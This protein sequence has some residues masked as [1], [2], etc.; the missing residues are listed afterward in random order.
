MVILD[1]GVCPD[2]HLDISRRFW[3]KL[4]KVENLKVWNVHRFDREL[5]LMLSGLDCR[6]GSWN[7]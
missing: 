5:N 3:L 4:A 7:M 6:F 1:L 2:L